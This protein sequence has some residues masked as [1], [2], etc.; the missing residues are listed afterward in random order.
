MNATSNSRNEN[1]L[2]NHHITHTAIYTIH[3]HL[4]LTYDSGY[5]LHLK[6]DDVNPII[7]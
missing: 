3:T 7:A 5:K 2:V 6:N 4:L 1:T